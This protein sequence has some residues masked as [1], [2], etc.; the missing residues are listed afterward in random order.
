MPIMEATLQYSYANQLCVNRWN[1]VSSGTPAAV[2]LSF[3]LAHAMVGGDFGSPTAGSMIGA[4]RAELVGAVNFLDLA[5]RDVYSDLDFYTTALNFTGLTTGDGLAP[6]SSY[7]F[8]T[9]R[10]RADIG[11]GFKRFAGVPE[12]AN[13]TAGAI[14]SAYQPALET[15]AEE[16]STVIGY[17]DEGNLINFTPAVVSKEKYHPPKNPTGWAYRYYEAGEAAQLEHIAIGVTW[18]PYLTLRSQTSRQIGR[19]Q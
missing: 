9:N 13:G 12:M 8:R 6:F 14:N 4:I 5:V 7:G 18:E 16:M 10:I 2:S 1:Y 19:G 11:R 3:A 17:D 15:I